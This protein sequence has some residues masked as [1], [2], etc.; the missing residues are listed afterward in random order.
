MKYFVLIMILGLAISSPVYAQSYYC[1]PEKM[2]HK[3][4]W[5]IQADYYDPQHNG[6]NWS[7]WEHRY[8]RKLKTLEDAR[9][10]IDTMLASLA[11]PG[12]FLERRRMLP[13]LYRRRHHRCHLSH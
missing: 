7:H 2:Y 5:L 10:A 12:T 4:W 11:E 9:K 3:A 1:D 8:D 6:Q 13:N